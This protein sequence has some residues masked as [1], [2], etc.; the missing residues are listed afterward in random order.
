[1]L[2]VIVRRQAEHETVHTGVYR[3][4]RPP[5]RPVCT[6]SSSATQGE[7]TLVTVDLRPGGEATALVL[8]HAGL[9]DEEATTKHEHGWHRITVKLEA[10]MHRSVSYE[11]S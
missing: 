9:A 3:E 4:I 2:F 7:A 6:W 8:T 1:M 5:Q 11:R 10:Y